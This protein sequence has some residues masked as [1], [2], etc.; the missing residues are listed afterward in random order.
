MARQPARKLPIKMGLSKSGQ[1]EAKLDLSERPEP[2]EEKER[3]IARASRK[4]QS[5]KKG[6]PLPSRK[7]AVKGLAAE[8]KVRVKRARRGSRSI[9][10]HAGG[11][12]SGPGEGRK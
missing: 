1:A 2:F 10:T 12:D 9:S 4:G 7:S 5:G 8:G 6:R 11:P 3:D